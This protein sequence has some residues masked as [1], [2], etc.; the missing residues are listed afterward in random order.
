VQLCDKSIDLWTI[1]LANVDIGLEK[2]EEILS[3]DERKRAERFVQ[4]RD[5]KRFMLV[6]S[7]LRSILSQYIGVPAGSI[8]FAYGIYGKPRLATAEKLQLEFN[9]THSGDYALCAV[10]KNHS[11]GIDIEKIRH[12]DPDH[13]LRLATRFFSKIESDALRAT[14]VGDQRL[15]FFSCWTRKEAY[16]KRHGLGLRLPLSGF[17][18]N[19]DPNES[20]RLI[21]TPWKPQDLMITSLQ[22]ISAPLGYSAALAIASGQLINVRRYISN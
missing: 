17:T 6:R 10:T 2:H 9:L 19:I 21:D 4:A 1:S 8:Q 7:N 14:P 11:I 12:E 15:F 3:S 20:A 5:G 18:V 16:L 22:D 13:Y